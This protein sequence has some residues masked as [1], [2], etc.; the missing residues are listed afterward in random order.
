MSTVAT[1]NAALVR[2]AYEA[3]GR[4][5]IPAVIDFLAPEVVWIE[6]EGGPY[7]GVYEGPQAVL[8]GIFAR[9]G[10]DWDGFVVDVERVLADGDTVVGI[11]TYRGTYRAT[12]REMVARVVHVW[13]IRDGRALRMEQFVDSEQLNAAAR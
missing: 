13:E 2:S 11:C 6:T 3:F 10:S 8:E 7:G 1:D 4:G 12:G 9:V 5:D